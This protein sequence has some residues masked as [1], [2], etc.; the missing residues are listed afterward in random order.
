MF[1]FP[2][3]E[4]EVHGASTAVG[5][6]RPKLGIEVGDHAVEA[7]YLSRWLYEMCTCMRQTEDTHCVFICVGLLCRDR[8]SP[9]DIGGMGPWPFAK[10]WAG[11]WNKL[12][13]ELAE[14]FV[15]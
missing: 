5:E 4:R 12:F 6:L 1:V 8:R 13:E 3:L 9:K 10:K 11:A 14:W 15:E 7:G 2:C